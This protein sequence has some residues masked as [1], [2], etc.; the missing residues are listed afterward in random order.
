[1]RLRKGMRVKTWCTDCTTYQEMKVMNG[2]VIC[3]NCGATYENA[4]FK[5]L[6]KT[7]KNIV[8][9]YM[10]GDLAYTEEDPAYEMMLYEEVKS[11]RVQRVSAETEG[12][13]RG[14]G[15]AV[16]RKDRPL[17]RGKAL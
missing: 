15:K 1:M 8:L 14:N 9:A 11:D 5:L 13:V 12:N 10:E 16:R 3:Q 7:Y 6:V 2:E 17:G 4:C